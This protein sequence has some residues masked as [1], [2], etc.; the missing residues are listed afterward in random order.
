M[1]C[2]LLLISVI[3][4]ELIMEGNTAKVVLQA[5]S[6][7]LFLFLFLLVVKISYGEPHGQ[8]M[9]KLVLVGLCRSAT[10]AHRVSF[11]SREGSHAICI[12]TQCTLYI[13]V[14][15][16]IR[17]FYSKIK[18]M[19]HRRCLTRI[20]QIQVPLN[21]RNCR[22]HITKT[23]YRQDGLISRHLEPNPV[24]MRVVARESIFLPA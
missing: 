24:Q 6:L 7:S 22:L 20:I 19:L 23:P 9:L 21:P 10:R 12:S 2:L 18:I 16:S 15:W 13:K 5:R 11:P 3:T 14:R 17:V 1:R 8:K 4:R